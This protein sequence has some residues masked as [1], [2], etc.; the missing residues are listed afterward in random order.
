ME[1][2]VFGHHGAR[3]LVF[4]TSLARFHE[5]EDR[6]LIGVLREHLDR[7]WLQLFCVDTIDHESWYNRHVHPADRARRH[8]QYDAYLREEVLP[9]T[10]QYNDN[11]YL[12]A[13]GASLGG[14]HASNFAFRHPHLVSR[15]LC[16]S[17]LHDIKR[18][19][20]GYH[21]ENIY[22]NCPSDFLQGEHDPWR[23]DALRRMDIILAVGRDDGLR[24][25]NE[26]LSHV[27]WARGVGNALRVW[28]GFAH[29]WPVWAR[30]LPLYI[31][32]HD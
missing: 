26:H 24:G 3:V 18:F 19:T 22:F 8:L 20:D 16:M 17:A 4:P 31:G 2:L 32:G 7:G 30:M 11:P 29:D 28:D 5:W 10:R 23:L 27:L 15:L 9:L 12:I 21:D 6:G 13:T 1:L 14:Y 25:S